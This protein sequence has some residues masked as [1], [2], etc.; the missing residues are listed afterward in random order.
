MVSSPGPVD[1]PC[2]NTSGIERHSATS[3][4]KFRWPQVPLWKNPPV[5][6]DHRSLDRAFRITVGLK[7][8]DGI[9]EVIG[10][11]V[12]LFVSPDSI[13]HF[14]RFL[15]AHELA[16]D[17]NDF[18][19]RHLLHSASQLTHSSTVYGGIYLLSHGVAKVVLVVLVLKD[20]LWAYPWMIGLIA[21]FIA[22]QVYRLTYKVSF[23]LI[24]LTLFD[25][26]VIWL[27]WREYRIKRT[28]L[29][30]ARS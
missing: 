1:H 2:N 16:Q 30:Q 13:S 23:G 25:M 6:P 15:T 17:P 18:I 5:A 12:L 20:K 21:V 19:A 14:I 9:L 27:T 10:G 11:L 7:G 3:L 28:A 24:V 26:L 29:H 4:T 22:Y 8:L